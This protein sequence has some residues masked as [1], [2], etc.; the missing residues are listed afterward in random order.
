MAVAGFRGRTEGRRPL[1][2]KLAARVRWSIL[3]RL[4]KQIVRLNGSFFDELDDFL[5]SNGQQGQLS[6]DRVYLK[7]MREFRAKQ[8]LFEKI[9]LSSMFENMEGSNSTVVDKT[10]FIANGSSSGSDGIY[11]KVETDL[12][13]KAMQRKAVKVYS[14]FI[15][16]IDS[17]NSKLNIAYREPV[18]QSSFLIEQTML[19]FSISLDVRLIFMKLFEQHFVLKMEKLYLDIISILTNVENGDFVDRLFLSSSAFGSEERGAQSQLNDDNSQLHGKESDEVSLEDRVSQLVKQ[20]CDLVDLPPFVES[21]IRTKWKAV[22]F[23]IGLNKSHNS[24]EWQEASHTLSLL[25]NYFD[26]GVAAPESEMKGFLIKLRQGL[27]L[28]QLDASEQD[29]LIDR[30]V[31][32]LPS[33]KEE[34]LSAGKFEGNTSVEES[35][36]S[37]F[38][39]RVLDQEDLKEISNLINDGS[40]SSVTENFRSPIA[41]FLGRIDTLSCPCQIE[42]KL[43]DQFVECELSKGFEEPASYQIK[44]VRRRFSIS[45]SKLGLAICLRDG[46]VRLPSP[47]SNEK[48]DQVTE[49]QPAYK[50]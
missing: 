33:Q 22:L 29:E 9:L 21:F 39:K 41:D 2:E 43:G 30:L 31:G 49:F 47:E 11:E 18:I 4:R 20:S 15:K 45:R 14:P 6:E 34:P 12:A 36:I 7:A 10:S 26:K 38:G 16:Q 46:E 8:A 23:L 28:I 35:S 5:F 17:L 37:P 50:D 27:S 44:S 13:L 3:Q 1:D 48:P 40:S 19:A 24:I 42:Y 32:L 25:L